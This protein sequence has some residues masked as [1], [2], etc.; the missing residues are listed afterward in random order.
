M[1]FVQDFPLKKRPGGQSD[2]ERTLTDHVKAINMHHP[3]DEFG[4]FAP[5]AT[6]FAR[7]VI[8][9]IS[10]YN[11]NAEVVLIASV[12]GRH[13]GENLEKYGHLKLKRELRGL[14]GVPT[15]APLVM[16]ASSISSMLE[17]CAFLKELQRSMGALDATLQV[18]WMTAKA[19]SEGNRGNNTG[20]GMIARAARQGSS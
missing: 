4:E 19:V 20:D 6:T 11:F 5:E 15:S 14:D 16:Q 2:F 13:T 17:G 1:I 18:P 3:R 9:R 12:P 7:A 8:D 10:R